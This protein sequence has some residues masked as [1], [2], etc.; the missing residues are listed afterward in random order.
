MKD[1]EQ[2]LVNFGSRLKNEREKHGL[3][4]HALAVKAHTKQDYIAQLERGIR[5]PSLKT[6]INILSALDISADTLIYGGIHDKGDEMEGIMKEFN[7]FLTR[8]TA[9]DVCYYYEIVRFHSQFVDSKQEY[10]NQ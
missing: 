2:W 10:N 4:Q 9:K 8:R 3:T 6:I 7:D 1:L 5:N